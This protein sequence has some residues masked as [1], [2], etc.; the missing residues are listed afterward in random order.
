MSSGDSLKA[1]ELAVQQLR[2][3][4]IVFERQSYAAASKEIG[5]SVPTIWE[6][7]QSLE[8]KYATVL[9]DREGRIVPT[10]SAELL[11][12]SLRPLLAGLDSTFERSENRRA[13]GPAHSRSSW[14]CG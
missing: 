2:S 9:F 8:R 12:E 14:A 4:C 13:R 11:Y 6:Q 1:N 5:L 3:F 7:V 10:A